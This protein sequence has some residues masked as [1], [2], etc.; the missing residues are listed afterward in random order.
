MALAKAVSHRLLMRHVVRVAEL[1]AESWAAYLHHEEATSRRRRD[2][3]FTL[4]PDVYEV[5]RQ[6]FKDQALPRPG[7]PDWPLYMLN[8]RIG[9]QLAERAVEEWRH[10][11]H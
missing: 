10:R 2:E 6:G 5:M 7:S 9:L 1:L 8:Q 3:A 11:D 4:D